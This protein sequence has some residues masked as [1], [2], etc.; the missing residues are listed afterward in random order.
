M[1]ERGEA[2]IDWLGAGGGCAETLVRAGVG[3]NESGFP[4]HSS[5]LSSASVTS[6]HRI[7]ATQIPSSFE[8]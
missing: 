2:D 4:R 5:V 6:L 7:S 3:G 1:V 8:K